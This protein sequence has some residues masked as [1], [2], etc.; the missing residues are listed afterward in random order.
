MNF[1]KSIINNE[2]LWITHC[3]FDGLSPYILN[4]FFNLT[5]GKEISTNYGELMELEHIH[6]YKN[7][8]YV[9]FTPCQQVRDEI[10]K[11]NLNCLILD[12]HEG[13]TEEINEWGKK[14]SKMEYIYDNEKCGTKLYYEWLKGQGFVG[15]SVSDYIVELTDTYDL[16]KQER[17][18]WN[19][20]ESCNRLMYASA[21]WSYKDDRFK[22]YEFFI[23]NMLWKMQNADK[24]FFNK[25][26]QT[27]IQDDINKENNLFDDLI[28][29]ASK[30]ISTRKDS[31]GHYFAIFYGKSKI[32]AL[33]NR[34]LNKYKKL[35]YVIIIND[36]NKDDIKISL[37]SRDEFNVLNLV[38][39]K[40]HA[41][42]GGIDTSERDTKELSEKLWKKEIYEL[43]YLND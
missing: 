42:A 6:L 3:D 10:E 33:A 18:N 43:G 13:V 11:Y 1:D 5:Y 7:V 19:I 38:G 26:E 12:H 40:G 32:S 36:Y 34:L 17:E 23:N 14:Y 27:H 22:C 21:R 35:D 20:A 28:H 4:K 8:V 37:R 29:N 2:T 9:D 15:N 24:F 25:L 16:Y 41:N 30:N 39:V 31:K